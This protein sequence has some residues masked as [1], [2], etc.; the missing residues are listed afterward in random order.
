MHNL[1]N[2][3]TL[4]SNT[5]ISVIIPVYNEEDLIAECLDA[6][7]L[8][9]VQPD[10]IY[11][12]D[13]NSTDTT[14][15]IAKKYPTVTIIQETVQGICAA[16]QTGLDAAAIMGGLLLRCDADSRPPIHWVEKVAATFND[17]NDTIAVTGPGVPYGVPK[18][19]QWAFDVLYMQPYFKLVGL[20]LGG[21]P[22]FGSN[23]AIKADV[24]RVVSTKTHLTAHQDIHDD[25]DISY[26][27]RHL[28]RTHY[29]T[30][31]RMPISARPFRSVRKLI[32]RYKAGFKS[33]FIHWPQQAPW[34]R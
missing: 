17:T 34:R 29:D 30:S 22:L 7:L 20:A 5:H 14:V 24:W 31:L 13:N 11:I 21:T 19:L 6:L 32:Q 12:V 23:F 2:D 16:T 9:T 15:S 25:I 26:H 33:I 18:L 8:Q 27:I 4:H 10:V 1:H 28:G 3:T